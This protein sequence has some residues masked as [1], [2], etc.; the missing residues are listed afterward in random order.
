MATTEQ[1]YLGLEVELRRR[2]EE[3]GAHELS[4]GRGEARAHYHA[5][6]DGLLVALLVLQQVRQPAQR[7]VRPVAAGA[8]A[9]ARGGA[10]RGLGRLHHRLPDVLGLL[11]RQRLVLR[12]AG[13]GPAARLQHLGPREEHVLLVALARG[14][15]QRRVPGGQRRLELGLGWVWGLGSLGRKWIVRKRDKI[16]T[17]TTRTFMTGAASPVSMAACGA[18]GCWVTWGQRRSDAYSRRDVRPSVRP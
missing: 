3:D 13:Q 14:P 18:G 1:T 10:A 15:E 4:A 6:G 16:E 5:D 11:E 9:R 7:R 2:G 17:R 12:Q 8:G